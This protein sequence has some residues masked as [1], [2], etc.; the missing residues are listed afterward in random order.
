M[1]VRVIFLTML[2][3]LLLTV[4]S[5][6]KRKL[7][8]PTDPSLV[9]SADAERVLAFEFEY[10]TDDSGRYFIALF[11]TIDK[12]KDANDDIV[13]VMLGDSLIGLDYYEND[14]PYKPLGWYSEVSYYI[15]GLTEVKLYINGKKKLTT[16]I[17]PVGRAYA[18]FPRYYDYQQPLT[19]DWSVA[20]TN[21][22]QFVR[23]ESWR[24]NV[25]GINIYPYDSYIKQVSDTTASVTFPAN[26]VELV[27]GDSL[28]THFMLCVEEVNYKIVGNSAVMVYQDEDQYYPW[29]LWKKTAALQKART[30][31]SRLNKLLNQMPGK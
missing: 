6:D 17:Q 12:G 4:T 8:V 29:P 27:N 25:N 9:T 7:E 16:M 19:L 2:A 21:Q 24:F 3:A 23:V 30:P 10:A 22:Y 1:Y 11:D 15:T 18:Y 14:I 28:Q 31:F 13:Q 26:C 20:S 5:C